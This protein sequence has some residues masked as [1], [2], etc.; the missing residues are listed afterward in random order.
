MNTRKKIMAV[1]CVI[2]LTLTGS[3]VFAQRQPQ[4]QEVEA[5]HSFL[6]LMGN[7]LSVAEKYV[8][9]AS[10]EETAMYLVIEKTVELYEHSGSKV[11]AIPELR[12]IL[13]KYEDNLTIRNMVH[14]KIAD[15]YKENG[16]IEKALD[17][18]NE[19]VESVR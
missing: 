19:I 8:K 4:S 3:S 2:S 7:Y 5:I 18:L 16:Q 11:K 6:D 12:R 13:V 9:L 15:L 10:S 14:L 1:I 17:E